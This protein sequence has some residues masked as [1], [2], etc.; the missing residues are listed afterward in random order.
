MDVQIADLIVAF[1]VICIV[2]TVLKDKYGVFLL[3]IPIHVAWLVGA[4][5]LARP[6]SLWARYLYDQRKMARADERFPNEDPG[7]P[8]SRPDDRPRE[9][10][11]GF[12]FLV[13]SSVV[14]LVSGLLSSLV[15]GAYLLIA[16]LT[17]RGWRA[18]R[19]TTAALAGLLVAGELVC[20]ALAGGRDLAWLAGGVFGHPLAAAGITVL[21]A[22]AGLVLLWRST[23]DSYYQGIVVRPPVVDGQG[24]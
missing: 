16:L 11:V 8:V 19:P 3:G 21:P 6:G 22:A 24:R 20:A 9:L 2:A 14:M 5:R 1:V 4:I 7:W 10:D 23:A 12:G 13:L 17:W 18:G 15:A